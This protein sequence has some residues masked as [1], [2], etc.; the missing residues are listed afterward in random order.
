MR[1]LQLD[2]NTFFDLDHLPEEVDDMRFAIFDNSDP[3][4]PDYHYIPL[5]FLESFNSPALVLRIFLLLK[6]KR[7]AEEGLM[8]CATLD[9]PHS[10]A[11]R[12]SG[13]AA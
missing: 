11:S 8:A 13:D 7:F 2:T 9:A 3:R 12:A 10:H 4:D 5:I 6:K 1:I